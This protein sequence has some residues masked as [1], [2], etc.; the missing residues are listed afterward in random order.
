MCFFFYVSRHFFFTKPTRARGKKTKCP[1]KKGTGSVSKTTWPTN[2]TPNSLCWEQSFY[3]FYF[4]PN[5]DGTAS[6]RHESLTFPDTWPFF[7]GKERS[8][9]CS[10]ETF[11]N[12]ANAFVLPR[13]LVRWEARSRPRFQ[14]KHITWCFVKARL[15]YSQQS[16]RLIISTESTLA[17]SFRWPD[18][19]RVTLLLKASAWFSHEGV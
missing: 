12:I 6:I 18:S 16:P 14:T 13:S 1:K 2:D 7:A 4:L 19:A 11:I 17:F 5:D 10:T 15:H 8:L 9:I 3:F